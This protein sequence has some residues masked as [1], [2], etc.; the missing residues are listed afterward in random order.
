MKKE[1]EGARLPPGQALTVKWPV[2]K[3]G[4]APRADLQT[5]A[6]RYFGL[7]SFWEVNSYHLHAD[8]WKEERYSDQETDAR[9]RMRSEAARRL[10]NRRP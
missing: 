8:P 7:V 9:Q 1:Q 2:L 10:R 4:E 3:Y 6:F 5:W